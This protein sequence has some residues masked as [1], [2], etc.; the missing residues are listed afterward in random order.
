[1]IVE[2]SGRDDWQAGKGDSRVSA[3]EKVVVTL[4]PIPRDAVE[5][6]SVAHRKTLEGLL[7]GF[8]AACVQEETL[9]K[10]TLMIDGYDDDPRE[11]Y[12]IP[13]VCVWAR[14][15][16]KQLP[17]LPFFL[18]DDSQYRFV[19]WLCGPASKSEIES[20]RFL[21]RFNET[22]A[23]CLG[24]A[25]MA[26]HDFL[27]RA[28]ASASQVYAFYFQ[29]MKVSQQQALAAAISMPKGGSEGVQ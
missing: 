10:I 7:G 23:T 11:L 22:K 12:E 24:E 21:E 14:D 27:V 29:N 2:E 17:S 6:P 1:L 16:V 26:S 8:V 28:G 3:D 5:H 19:G 18:D 25:V 15:S 9:R 4:L 13:E 20:S